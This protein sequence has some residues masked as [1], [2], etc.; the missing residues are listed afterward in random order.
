[1][2]SI[3]SVFLG[4]EPVFSRMIRLHRYGTSIAGILIASLLLACGG[5]SDYAGTAQP[6]AQ[7]A[8]T[9]PAL[10]QEPGLPQEAGAPAF[11]NNT[12]QDG[13]NWINFRRVQVGVAALV[14]NAQV[15]TAAQSHSV[16]LQLNNTVS[17]E[18]EPGKPGFT[19]ADLLARLNAAGYVFGGGYAYGEV[20]SATSTPSGF[21]MA[22]ELI[23]AVYHRF[24]IFEPKFKEIGTG[25]ASTA[26]G[27]TYFTSDFTANHG[28]GPGLGRNGTV[29]WPHDRQ[30]GVPVNFF[31]D[32]ES[33][34]PVPEPGMNEVGYPVSIH[35]DIDVL[36]T[37]QSF[38]LRPRGGADL[39]VKLLS[40]AL[41][42]NTPQSA[43]AI[44]PLSPL[45]TGTVYDV[46]FA[47]KTDSTAITRNWSFTTK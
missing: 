20:I 16:Y 11:L 14:P 3:K 23:A 26:V 21:Y 42:H 4:I 33:P 15:A 30:A 8:A 37:V 36:L 45:K 38:T 10:P 12:A 25:S 47:G 39:P 27:Y 43:A 44:I 2:N 1:M 19:G 40:A 18:E 41:D 22:E 24:V 29:S 17:H 35:A 7:V 34:D 6:A 46:A 31:S 28:F 9:A 32:F 5:G 13:L